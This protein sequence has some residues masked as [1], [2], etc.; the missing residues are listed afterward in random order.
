MTWTLSYKN[1]SNYAANFQ[2]IHILL[3]SGLL[4]TAQGSLLSADP[5]FWHL[6]RVLWPRYAMTV[7]SNVLGTIPLTKDTKMFIS[8]IKEE[9]SKYIF[10]PTN[11]GQ[12]QA[13][14][15]LISYVPDMYKRIDAARGND[16]RLFGMPVHVANYPR[17]GFQ[18]LCSLQLVSS[19][20]IE[21]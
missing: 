8:S 12:W 1:H 3:S 16:I 7:D 4:C 10:Y 15:S 5:I 17:V 6:R 14:F 2:Q 18:A 9:S 20:S 19:C 11:C 21:I 13:W